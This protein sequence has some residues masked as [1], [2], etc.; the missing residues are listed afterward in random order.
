MLAVYTE[1]EVYDENRLIELHGLALPAYAPRRWVTIDFLDGWEGMEIVTGQALIDLLR[2]KCNQA[3]YRLWIASP[4]IGSYSSVCRI[5]GSK[6]LTDPQISVRL[7]TDV[8]E[9]GRLSRETIVAFDQR[10]SVKEVRGLH[11]KIYIIDDDALITSANLTGT[12][13]SKRYEVGGFLST[14]ESKQ[15]IELYESWWNETAKD[16]PVNWSESLSPQED[17]QKSQEEKGGKT[18]PELWKLPKAPHISHEGK[19]QNFLDYGYF[20]DR[21]HD[22]A[23][24]YST[25]QRISPDMPLYLEVDA[26]LDFLFHHGTRPSFK[27]RRIRGKP[28]LPPRELSSEEKVKEIQRYA[29]L[30]RQWVEDG[31]DIIWRQSSS[32]LIRKKLKANN[33]TSLQ[34]HEVAEVVEQLN[35]MNSLPLNK[36]RFLNPQNND[37][38]TIRSAWSQLLYGEEGLQ[39][40]MAQCKQD[41]RYFGNSS[42]Q[43]LLGFFAPDEYPIRNSNS[44][45]GL[46]FFGYDVAID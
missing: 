36:T 10:G 23:K 32:R 21:Y 5:L 18:L 34:R 16:I 45:A 30:F 1:C 8:E 31:H 39:K 12:A 3:K 26:F 40:R 4:Y 19:P 28:L 41:L 2:K 6:W 14:E 43:E 17:E 22:F 11:A 42:V 9:L 25:V 15:L 20:R 24:K 37:I 46:R 13:F 33:I 35:C 38:N 44:N 27:Y 7:L 29:P